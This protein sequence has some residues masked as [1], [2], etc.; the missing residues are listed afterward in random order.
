VTHV[1]TTR[2]THGTSV[3]H[4]EGI[5]TVADNSTDNWLN[6]LLTRGRLCG[7]VVGCH[8]AQTWAATWHPFVGWLVNF[9]CKMLDSIGFDL[10]TSSMGSALG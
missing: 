10:G 7:Q 3:Q 2:V 4:V 8:M 9:C 6:D 1:T 5:G